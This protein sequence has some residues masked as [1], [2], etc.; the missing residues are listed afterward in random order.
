MKNKDLKIFEDNI[1]FLIFV[2]MDSAVWNHRQNLEEHDFGGLERI[3]GFTEYGRHFDRHE[4]ADN[5]Q[6]GEIVVVSDEGKN[7]G[8]EG[9]QFCRRRRF[10]ELVFEGLPRPAD[11]SGDRG[12]ES[13]S[14]ALDGGDDDGHKQ[15]G[16][17]RAGQ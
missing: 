6:I 5:S 14:V 8:R 3:D 2:C 4:E 16:S 13:G 9:A 12:H 17:V 15:G 10:D 7:E 11:E 1:F